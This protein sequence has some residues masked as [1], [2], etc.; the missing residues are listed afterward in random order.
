M[1]RLPEI[2]PEPE[3]PVNLPEEARWLSG[4]GAGSWFVINEISGGLMF[5]V[6]RYSPEGF[7]ECTGIFRSESR[8]LNLD[9]PY[10][11][12]YPSHCKIITISREGLVFRLLS[13]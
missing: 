11:I 9:L 12:T 4:E 10:K 5:E 7:P 3:R 13:V 8:E 6:A 1:I 2:L